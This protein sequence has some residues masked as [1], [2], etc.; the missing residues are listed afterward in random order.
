MHP[1]SSWV[2][3]AVESI[4]KGCGDPQAS[5]PAHRVNICCK[6]IGKTLLSIGPILLTMEGYL[7]LK[8]SATVKQHS[9]QH[10]RL[11]LQRTWSAISVIIFKGFYCTEN[12]VEILNYGEHGQN[13]SWILPSEDAHWKKRW[14]FSWS[15]VVGSSVRNR[16]ILRQDFHRI[17]YLSDETLILPK[18]IF[19]WQTLSNTLHYFI[20]L[21]RQCC[22]IFSCKPFP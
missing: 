1:K 2:T 5:G 7:W 12:N 13:Y 3:Q 20:Y 18:R 8:V 10:R 14:S 22:E 15:V 17:K 11:Q 4:Y 19:P 6:A 9:D 16:E 21:W